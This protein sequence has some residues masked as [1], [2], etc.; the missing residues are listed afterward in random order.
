MDATADGAASG[1]PISQ[2][3]L[4]YTIFLMRIFL[5]SFAFSRDAVILIVKFKPETNGTVAFI[6]FVS[7]E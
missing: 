5:P 7:L 6:H 3:D 2:A 4:T 1:G